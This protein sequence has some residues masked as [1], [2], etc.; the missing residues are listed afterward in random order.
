MQ[1][2]NV[3]ALGLNKGFPGTYLNAFWYIDL[4]KVSISLV[5][6]EKVEAVAN[7]VKSSVNIHVHQGLLFAAQSLRAYGHVNAASSKQ[8]P[9]S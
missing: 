7:P 6:V 4:H 5:H 8:L 3:A 2:V 1:G 9:S